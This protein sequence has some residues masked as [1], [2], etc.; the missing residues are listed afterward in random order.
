MDTPVRYVDVDGHILEP[1]GLWEEYIEPKYR[2]RAF[3]ILEDENGLEYLSID[4][5]SSW[6]FR[7]GTLGFTGA[8]G[9][10]PRPFLE[11]GRIK[12]EDPVLPRGGFDPHE[13]VKVMDAEGIDQTLIYPSLS[14]AMECTDAELVAANCRA[15]NNWVFDF[16]KTHPKRLIPVAHI[17]V[18]DVEEGV[19]ELRRTAKLGAKAAMIPSVCPLNRPFGG[20]YFDPLWQEAQDLDM[21]ITLHPAASLEQLTSQLYPPKRDDASGPITLDPMA[22]AE[23]VSSPIDPLQ[24]D[25]PSPWLMFVLGAEDTKFQFTTFF[26]EGTFERFP[27]LK[28]VVLESGTGWLVHLLQ[29]MDD[30]FELYGFTTS[31]KLKPS[32]Y[33]RRN[34]W[35]AMDPDDKMVQFNVQHLGSE[36]FLWAYD[37]PHSD[38]ITEPVSKLDENLAFLPPESRNRIIGEN[39]VE[40]YHL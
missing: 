13:R 14:L 1:H 20:R 3:K 32:E 12:W 11:P 2:D 19:K 22:A 9:Q 10:D 18:Q 39:A 24:R 21:P 4:G 5:K 30:M 27:R 26:A 36:R 40:L 31:M 17:P 15:Y 38:S 25:D 34:C 33:F 23:Q 6:L 7:G 35:I 8:I 37:F 29:R 16:C 28:L